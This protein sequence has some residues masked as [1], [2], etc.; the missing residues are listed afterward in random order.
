MTAPPRSQFPAYRA[1]VAPSPRRSSNQNG[2][3]DGVIARHA[4]EL[5]ALLRRRLLIT[6]AVCVGFFGLLPTGSVVRAFNSDVPLGARYILLGQALLA[7]ALATI[8][9]F[10]WKRPPKRLRHLRALE[11]VIFGL[12]VGY[13]VVS[14]GYFVERWGIMTP[15]IDPV[16]HPLLSTGATRLDPVTLRWFIVVV[17]Y[18][19]LIPNTWR[20]GA[21]VI[22]AIVGIH[23]AELVAQ[24]MMSGLGAR[25]MGSLLLYPMVWMTIATVV[26]VFGSYRVSLLERRVQ[27]AERLGQYRLKRF[28]GAGGMGDVYLAEHVLLKQPFAVKLLRPERILDD[29]I[30]QRFEAEV[31]AMA[32]L[33][34]WNTVEIYDYG[35]AADGSFYYVM[36]YLPGM[37]LDQIVAQHGPLP[38][39]RAIRMLLQVCNALNEAHS[40]GLTHRDIKPGNILVCER[41]G[42]YDVA[43]LLDF[44]LVKSIE[45]RDERLTM[46][47]TIAGTPAFMSPEQAAGITTADVRSDIYSLGAVAYFLLTARPPFSNRSATQI[48]AAHIY[49][50]PLPISY[51]RSDVDPQLDAVVQRCLAKKPGERYADA[52]SL[53]AALRECEAFGGWTQ[54]D[55]MQWWRDRDAATMTLV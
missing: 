39:S 35:H 49:E 50:P 30:L 55:A 15:P 46:E 28:L 18:G 22:S 36:E 4:K 6:V 19:A 52:E 16:R 21:I 26:A 14:N 5:H 31:Q 34:H 42:I 2:G 33:Q 7:L 40:M 29:R 1:D 24:A 20:R 48:M 12:V 44:G 43:K 41:A 53:A 11:L 23:V 3:L 54:T 13:L 25:E 10:L 9:V 17:G 47:G 8:G 51:Y 27:E 37:T 38:S 45:P 32:R